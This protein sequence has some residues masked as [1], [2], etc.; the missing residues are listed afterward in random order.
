MNAKKYLVATLAL[1]TVAVAFAASVCHRLACETH[2]GANDQK[3]TAYNGP[4]GTLGPV[5]ERVLADPEPDGPTDILNLETGRALAQA[6]LDFNSRA[7]AIMNWIRTNGLDISCFLW[8][9]GAAC[10]TYNMTILPVEK[11]SWEKTTADDLLSNPNLAPGLHSPRRLLILGNNRPDTYIF[12]TGEGTLGMLRIVGLSQHGGG[13]AIRY[14]L[15][16]TAKTLRLPQSQVSISSM[17]YQPIEPSEARNAGIKKIVRRRSRRQPSSGL[18]N[19][20]LVQIGRVLHRIDRV[21][22]ARPA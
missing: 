13:V 7:D 2:N 1:S 4:V 18:K 14:K 15:I 19:E 11:D 5:T 17:L 6:P 21:G 8:P 9:G 22:P 12:R 10:I 20:A 16:S 3:R